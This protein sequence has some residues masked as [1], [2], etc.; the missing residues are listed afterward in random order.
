MAGLQY[1]GNVGRGN[2]RD[3]SG[4]TSLQ[5]IQSTI[6]GV[7][8][9]VGVERKRNSDNN[10]AIHPYVESAGQFD[11]RRGELLFSTGTKAPDSNSGLTT[12]IHQNRGK[13]YGVW[14]CF[15]GLSEADEPIFQGVSLIDFQQGPADRSRTNQASITSA[16]HGIVDVPCSDAT[17]R[18]GES[19]MI[20]FPPKNAEQLARL[21]PYVANSIGVDS[22][23]RRVAT[24]VAFRPAGEQHA[25]PMQLYRSAM[26]RS[27]GMVEFDIRADRLWRAIADDA[28][29]EAVL[30]EVVNTISLKA[31][32]EK[33]VRSLTGSPYALSSRDQKA[34][35]R[36]AAQILMSHL[37]FNSTYYSSSKV[38]G[39]CTKAPENGRCAIKLDL[40]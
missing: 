13:A 9:S 3:S 21:D 29:S 33:L 32:S 26:G 6:L 15:N 36:L 19:V 40:G 11:I 17:L 22:A 31:S 39:V 4:T 16:W 30:D 14:S 25:A 1:Y 28:V 10:T 8:T 35:L 20:A 34:P 37:L 7:A 18:I 2:S 23:N 24:V 12:V 38:I 5:G 27:S